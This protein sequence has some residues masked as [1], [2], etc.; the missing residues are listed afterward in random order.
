VGD[1]LAD[2]SSQTVTHPP[3]F[4]AMNS[5]PAASGDIPVTPG[6]TGPGQKRD[7]RGTAAL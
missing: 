5:T 3:P 6:V 4:S 1:V 7:S 2:L